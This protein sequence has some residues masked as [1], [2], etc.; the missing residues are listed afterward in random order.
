MPPA[1]ASS[2]A[3]F[4]GTIRG[5]VAALMVAT[6]AVALVFLIVALL[7]IELAGTSRRVPAAIGASVFAV[8][9]IPL[10]AKM[11]RLPTSPAANAIPVG[12][13]GPTPSAALIV[14]AAVMWAMAGLFWYFAAAGVTARF[15]V[16]PIIFAVPL[17]IYP[18]LV[19]WAKKLAAHKIHPTQKE[20]AP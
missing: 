18:F 1:S 6:A 9:L 19:L 17:S 7:N 12:P 16:D 11:R 10:L 14:V 2:S 13:A 5:R 8:L 3:P 4:G 15:G 20:Q